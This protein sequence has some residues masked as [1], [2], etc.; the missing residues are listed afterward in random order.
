MYNG[1]V[2]NKQKML[3]H[4]CAAIM[5]T[6]AN[7]TERQNHIVALKLIRRDETERTWCGDFEKGW[8]VRVVWSDDPDRSDGY[9]DIDVTG[10]S[11]F[12]M[13]DDVWKFIS[14]KF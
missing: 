3:D 2:E 1:L 11:G 6:Q 10:D 12:G 4:L 7:G 13:L 14:R 5:E 9:Y 8:Y